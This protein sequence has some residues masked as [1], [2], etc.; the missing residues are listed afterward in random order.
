MTKR[1]AAPAAGT[2]DLLRLTTS[3]VVTALI[4]LFT[5]LVKVPTG[6]G[7]IHL[8]D[9]FVLLYAAATGDPLALFAGALG[10]A[11]ADIAGGYA[12]YAP[13]TAVIKVLIALPV[14]LSVR[15]EQG[16]GT[17]PS[18]RKLLTRN[19]FRRDAADVGPAFQDL[20]GL[21]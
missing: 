4:F 9:A 20:I 2:P 15:R 21:F 16:A 19:T 7:Y 5:F 13:V 14:V 8:G 17:R 3:A 6:V 11:L 18:D 1:T 10:E 12:P